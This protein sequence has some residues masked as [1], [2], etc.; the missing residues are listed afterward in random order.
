[1]TGAVE[2]QRAMNERSR[3]MRLAA[4][5]YAHGFA[6]AVQAEA[7]G[8]DVSEVMLWQRREPL[9]FHEVEHEKALMEQAAR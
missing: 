4:Q 6:V 7:A 8:V 1:M 5:A 2:E 3:K 9:F